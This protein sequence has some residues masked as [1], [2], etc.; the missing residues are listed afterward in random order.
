MCGGT[1]ILKKRDASW[2]RQL[3][4][5][6]LFLHFTAEWL[7]RSRP[8]VHGFCSHLQP[9]FVL[10]LMSIKAGI[11]EWEGRGK[12][13]VE[14]S[15]WGGFWLAASGPAWHVPAQLPLPTLG[16]KMV[17]YLP[18]GSGST[19][20]SVQKQT[21]VEFLTPAFSFW[22]GTWEYIF[23]FCVEEGKW[24]CQQIVYFG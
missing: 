13:E 14:A 7:Q 17:F 10:F 9:C 15:P 21:A 4:C 12:C 2:G 11:R 19:V 5:P 22:M 18:R 24:C 8:V 3:G 23:F 16:Q 20:R 1:T 6:F